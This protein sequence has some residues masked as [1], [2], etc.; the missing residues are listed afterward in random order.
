MKI[1]LVLLAS[2]LLPAGY[3]QSPPDVSEIMNRVGQ[4][5]TRAETRRREF[6]YTQKQTL[7]MIRPNGK[8]AR[9]EHRE[10]TVVPRPKRVQKKLVRFDGRY[11]SKGK[12]FSYDHPDYHYKGMDID[13]DLINSLSE[14]L[15]N[16]TNSRDGISSNLFPLTEKAVPHYAFKLIGTE[17]YHGR[18][19][20]RVHFEP[21]KKP[22]VGDMDDDGEN[23]IWKGDAL[24]DVAE[25]QPVSVQTSLAFK[26]PA[27]VKI[28]LGT[29]INGL[30][31]AI[32][33]E[34]FDDGVW[35]PV[36]YG[37]E[38]KVRGLFLYQRTMTVSLLNSD[39][40]KQDVNS[41]IA[42]TDDG[43]Q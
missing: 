32:T 8:I 23:G 33:Y 1:P 39:F 17:T 9:E 30:G 19:V 2:A 13:G 28:L 4:N 21:R 6:V 5:Q 16:D 12:Y 36:S 7:R 24:I 25:L 11:E 18:Q 3:A 41:S 34:K 42:Y 31:Y 43:K 37:G 38:F 14:D 40:R 27:A 15:T 26:V 22:S 10:Y 20:Y 35:F 29:N